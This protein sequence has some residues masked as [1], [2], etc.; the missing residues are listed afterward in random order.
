MIKFI[1]SLLFLIFIGCSNK[2]EKYIT[3][4]F[5]NNSNKNS[6]SK[7]VEVNKNINQVILV[8]SFIDST[9]IGIK[10]QV[11]VSLEQ[12]SNND[13]TYVVII[14]REKIKSKWI[15]N[16]KLAHLK[17]G[18]INCNVK[19]EDFNNDGYKDLTY[20]S[21]VAARGANEVRSLLIF[22]KNKKEL[23]LIRNSTDYPNLEYNE[24][25]NCVDSWMV[26]GGTSTVFLK[27]KN[28]SLKEFAGV[29]LFG[30]EREIY[31]VNEKRK[32]KTIK[33]EIIESLDIY[34]RFKNYKPL[35]E[36]TETR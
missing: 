1:F 27:I 8:E 32:K 36:N 17:D 19:I 6:A 3:T 10:G 12:F 26:Y 21:A 13:S 9:E 28:D 35:I 11:K 23:N 25:L 34:T 30:N 22:N 33:K 18:I 15:Q 31:S 4:T 2:N 7:K 20:Q 29:S 24:V 14:L 5:K 16:Q